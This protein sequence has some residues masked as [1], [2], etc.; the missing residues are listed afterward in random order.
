MNPIPLTES[1]LLTTGD[2]TEVI[3]AKNL[4]EQI[5]TIV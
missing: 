1:P 5:R 2:Q 4:E 3:F